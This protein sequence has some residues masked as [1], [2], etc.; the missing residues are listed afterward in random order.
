MSFNKLLKKYKM[1][2]YQFSKLSGIHQPAVS[3]IRTGK[4]SLLNMRLHNCKRV[5]DSF[6]ITLDELYEYVKDDKILSE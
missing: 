1:T 5:A 3:Q 4:R 2:G 6:G